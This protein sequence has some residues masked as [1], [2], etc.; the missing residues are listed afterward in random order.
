MDEARDPEFLL[1]AL[2]L[3][4]LTLLLG[5]I[6]LDTQPVQGCPSSSRTR[7]ASS[8]TH[9]TRP[10]PPM[11]RYSTLKGS[12]VWSVRASSASTRSLSSGCTVLSQCSSSIIFD[13]GGI[14][15]WS[16]TVG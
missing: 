10:S 8:R 5:D 6:V 15:V 7:V 1:D 13:S 12:P 9:T 11:T 4:R 3:L 2:P 14:R 16:R